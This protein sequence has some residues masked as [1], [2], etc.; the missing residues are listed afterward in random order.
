MPLN[1][2]IKFQKTLALAA[3]AST[4]FEAEA[5]ELAARRMM[6][7]YNIDP[8]DI[9]DHSLYSRTN[10]ADNE[11]LKRL[12]EEWREAHPVAEP[13]V[14]EPTTTDLSAF[15]TIEFDIKGFSRHVH[16]KKNRRQAVVLTPAD[17]EKIR[18]LFNEDRGLSEVAELTG[19]SRDTIN[20]T[21]AYHIRKNKWI[22]DS[23]GKF[24]WRTHEQIK[25]ADSHQAPQTAG[26]PED[27]EH[28]TGPGHDP[29]TGA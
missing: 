3:S 24:Q 9:P 25:R 11:L 14:E 18:V 23:D 27:V 1:S 7:A 28:R 22:R 21:R 6:A 29:G 12:R 16:G 13:I 17:Y 4:Q 19:F 26:E 10:F 5:A 2:D 8:T 20:S 15:P